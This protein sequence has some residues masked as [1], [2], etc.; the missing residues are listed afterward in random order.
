M[1]DDFAVIFDMD[2]VLIDS[3]DA[4]FKSWLEMTTQQGF[5]FTE[6]DFA[7][8][9]GRT[10][11]ENITHFWGD[12]VQ[13]DAEIA[14]MEDYKENAYRRIIADNF[15]AMP[16]IGRL[17]DDLHA[18]GFKLAVG[19][20]GPPENVDLALDHLERRALFD[21]VTT[22]TDVTRGKPDPQVFLLAAERMGVSPR[23]CAVIEDAA[24]GV[25]AAN[26]GGMTAI[27]LASTGRTRQSLAAARLVVDS[28]DEL[29]PRLIG[30][31]IGGGG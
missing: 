16:G 3:Y 20:S 22:A 30:E 5:K 9:F 2:G 19:S 25:T 11:R 15:P 21:A 7:I 13:D 26:A 29:S 23:H 4:H 31:L 18:A 27:G 1:N 17:L 8:S 6:E 24:A 14:R 28:L 10:T 12:R